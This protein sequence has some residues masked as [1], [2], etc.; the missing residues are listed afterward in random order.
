MQIEAH[1]RGDAG[2]AEQQTAKI[3]WPNPFAV[4]KWRR[5]QDADQWHGRDQQAGERAGDL[6]F[7]GCEGQPGDADLNQRKDEQ[8]AP[9]VEEYTHASPPNCDWQ[10]YQRP[11]R[12]PKEH[13]RRGR[14]FGDCDADEQIR[15]APD[16]AHRNEEQ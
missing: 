12:C 3:D 4:A 15:D 11:N 2:D 1:D 14:Q 16:Q 10:Q 8:C 5:D 9:L 6:L 13:Q 7:S